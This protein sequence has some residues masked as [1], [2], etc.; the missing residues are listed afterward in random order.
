MTY[1]TQFNTKGYAHLVDFLDVECAE[2]LTQELKILV[3]KGLTIK[4]TQCPKSEAIHGAPVFDSLLEQLQPHFEQASGKHLL[5]TYAYAR[6]YKPGEVLTPHT[7]RPAC[8]VSATITLGFSGTPWP[9]YMADPTNDG[10]PL[11]GDKQLYHVKNKAAITMKPGEAVLYKGCEKVHWR[12]EF[13]GDWAAQV[14]LHY[15]D[16]N[17]PYANQK[18]DGRKRLSHHPVE[19]VGGPVRVLLNALSKE[20]CQRVIEQCE[21]QHLEQA[22]IGD[23]STATIDKSIRDVHKVNLPTHIGIGATMAG[24]GLAVN[25]EHYHFNITRSN[26][27]DFL[28]YDMNGHYRSH[29]DTFLTPN[30]QECRKLTVLLFLNDDFE[31]GRLFIQNGHEKIYPV[32]TAGTAVVFPSFLLHG[33]EPVTSGIR[34]S[35][36]TWMVGPWFQ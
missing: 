25:Y 11:Q 1:T 24:I 19:E 21:K 5:P 8:E 18:Y 35:L 10:E 22:G 31:G 14:F 26:Q 23:S 28:R 27:V 3:Q 2:Q 17:G 6:L 13:C 16:A 34:R 32:Q 29:I 12:E 9:I 30:Q 15:V 20:A 7:D 36:V 33:V 4:D